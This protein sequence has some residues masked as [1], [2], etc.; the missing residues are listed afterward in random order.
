MHKPDTENSHWLERALLESETATLFCA[1]GQ[2]P[3]YFNP[4]VLHVWNVGEEDLTTPTWKHILQ[5]RVHA[6]A[7]DETATTVMDAPPS[8]QRIRL[9]DGRWLLQ[10]KRPVRGPAGEAGVFWS[11]SDITPVVMLEGHVD[12]S[13]ALLNKLSV[14]VPGIIFKFKMWPDG[15]ACFPYISDAVST[16]YPGVRPEDLVD[17]ATPFFAFRHPE[18]AA[19]LQNSMLRSAQTMQ[20]WDHEYRLLLPSAKVVWRHGTARPERQD[21]GSIAWH[22]IIMDIT[23]RKLAEEELRLNSLVFDTSGE[24]ILVLDKRHAIVTVNPAFV[25]ITGFEDG[26]MAGQKLGRLSCG[27]F[28]RFLDCNARAELRQNGFWEGEVCGRRKSGELLATWLRVSNVTDAS[29]VVTHRVVVFED[30]SEAKRASE[31]IWRQA[32]FDH[33]TGLPNRKL[34]YERVAHG[35]ERCGRDGQ[36]LAL[37]LLDLDFFK[38]INDTLGHMVGDQL[39]VEAARRMDALVLSGDTMARLG[40]DEFAVLLAGEQV[41]SLAMS[42]ADDLM[43]ALTES[44]HVGGET[45]HMTASMGIAIYPSDGVDVHDLLKH[46]EQALYAAKSK[47]RNR[48]SWFTP[49]LHA[50]AERKRK[51]AESLHSALARNQL[52]VHYQPVV[53]LATG[54]IVKAEAL[55]RWHS[56]DVPQV[57]PAEFI[58]IAEENGLIEE[59]GD[60]VFDEVLQMSKRLER[61]FGQ[62]IQI[63]VNQSPRQFGASDAS[64]GWQQK[65]E[66]A[67]IAADRVAI[68]ITEGLLLDHRQEVMAQLLA[69]RKAGLQLALDDFG[70]GYSAMSYLLKFQLDLLKIDQSFVRNI[71]HAH[72][73]AIIEAMVVMAHKLGLKVVAE[74]VESEAE[75]AFLAS[76]GCEFAQGYL[77]SKPVTADAL[78][79]LLVAEPA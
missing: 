41:D 20:T 68:E 48:F 67:G 22:G 76:T 25:R 47:G 2:Q 54:R 64:V 49:S 24:G 15:R 72:G 74:G 39:L 7:W 14:Q 77:F 42:K 56:T 60:W 69:L 29:G 26:E 63:A 73:Q 4:S 27:A 46:A 61:R 3:A 6:P 1:P 71:E 75:R 57:G 5:A 32:H 34:L 36:R 35:M 79:S 17:D 38:E 9:T 50:A 37:L 58:P 28:A 18:D 10:R 78:E 12:A 62:A 16:M 13:N 19:G 66:Q 23:E 45:V 59:I 65:L 21:D 52:E 43:A 53:D 30:I 33:L 44:F 51:L 55:L 40:G 8:M 31:H 70:T 11:W